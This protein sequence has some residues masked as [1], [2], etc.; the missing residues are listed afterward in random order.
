MHSNLSTIMDEL[1]DDDED[2]TM[3][4]LK[5]EMAFEGAARASLWQ[6]VKAARPEWKM[7]AVALFASLLEGWVY[8]ILSMLFTKLIDVSC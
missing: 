3:K 2:E 8:P 6:I 5:E 1:A 7:L 4:R